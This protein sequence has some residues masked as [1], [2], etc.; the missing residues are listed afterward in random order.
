[1]R[2]KPRLDM[3]A[4]L[5]AARENGRDR[6]IEFCIVAAVRGLVRAADDDLRRAVPASGQVGINVRGHPPHP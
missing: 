5:A 3:P 6:A 2:A 4:L 1:V